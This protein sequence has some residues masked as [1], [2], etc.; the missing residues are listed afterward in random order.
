MCTIYNS[1]SSSVI[2]T[3]VFLSSTDADYATGKDYWLPTAESKTFV[4]PPGDVKKRF[5]EKALL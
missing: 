4:E 3:I 1:M 5:G 2:A